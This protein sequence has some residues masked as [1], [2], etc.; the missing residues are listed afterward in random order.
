MLLTV[1]VLLNLIITHCSHV[2]CSQPQTII[3]PYHMTFADVVGRS[4]ID[5]SLPPWVKRSTVLL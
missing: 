3:Q 2:K 5:S 4:H 1:F